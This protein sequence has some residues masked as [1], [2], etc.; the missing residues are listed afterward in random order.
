MK[1]IIQNMKIV[2]TAGDDYAGPDQFVQAPEGFDINSPDKFVVSL[3]DDVITVTLKPA[4]VSDYVLAMEAMFDAKAKERS[5]DTRY[6]CALRAG[7]PSPFQAEGLAFATWMDTCNGI[8][9]Q[10]LNDFQSGKIPPLTIPELL[11][12]LPE[13][14]WP[15]PV[16]PLVE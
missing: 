10:L 15:S 14:E 12:S 16:V 11:A 5:Y 7:Y 1:V 8:G 13:L 4:G 9:L 6:T 3:V 2:G